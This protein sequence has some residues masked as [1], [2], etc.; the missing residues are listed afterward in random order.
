ME[1]PPHSQSQI[2]LYMLLT[3]MRISFD[4]ESQCFKEQV[5]DFLQN[6]GDW[7]AGNNKEATLA[8]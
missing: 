8:L 7:K 2:K 1:T 3:T 4:D 5:Q 6:T